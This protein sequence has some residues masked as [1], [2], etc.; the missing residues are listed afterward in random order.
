MKILSIDTATPICGVSILEDTHTI[1]QSDQNADKSHSEILMPMIDQAF[2]DTNLSIQD[3][4]L[5][6]CDHGPGSFTGIR[7]GIA[8]IKA[9]HDALSIPCIGVSSLEAL[10]YMVNNEGYVV[11]LMDAKNQNC[12]FALY[13]QTNHSYQQILCPMTDTIENAFLLLKETIKKEH[14]TI[15]FVGDRFYFLS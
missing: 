4:D 7:I 11:S 12:Y 14:L 3:I 8:T 5:L 9:F 13:E 1:Y 10:A 15:T 2:H 6:V